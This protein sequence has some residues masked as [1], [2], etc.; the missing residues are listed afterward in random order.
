ML[1]TETATYTCTEAASTLEQLFKRESRSRKIGSRAGYQ[2]G[3][4]FA[5]TDE[6]DEII[7]AGKPSNRVIDRRR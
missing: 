2:P 6:A 1:Q 4:H 5:P 7:R 3:K